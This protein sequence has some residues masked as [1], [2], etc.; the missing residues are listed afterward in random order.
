MTNLRK[1]PICRKPRSAE[2]T[3][4]CSK[5]CKDRD[6]VRWLADGYALPGAPAIDEEEGKA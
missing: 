2:F 4:F 6:L 3:P 5:S 1:C